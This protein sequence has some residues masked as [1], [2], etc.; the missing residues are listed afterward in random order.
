MITST[1]DTPGSKVNRKIAMELTVKRADNS[2]QLRVTS[3]WKKVEI[4]GKI[5]FKTPKIQLVNI[6]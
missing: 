4:T 1:I 2:L 5:E 3:P 6:L